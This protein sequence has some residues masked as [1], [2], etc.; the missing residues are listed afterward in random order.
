MLTKVTKFFARAGGT[1]ALCLLAPTAHAAPVLDALAGGWNDLD[2]FTT[3]GQC[4]AGPL[5]ASYRCSPALLSR[6]TQPRFEGK[7]L[8]SATDSV[9]SISDALR[10]ESINSGDIEKLFK[11]YNYSD[12]IA[13]VDLSYFGPSLTVGLRPIRYQ[14]QFQVHN[15]NLP[16]ASLAYRKDLD[17]HAGTGYGWQLGRLNLSAGALVSVVRREETLVEATLLDLAS[18][19]AKELI[20]KQKLTGYFFDFGANATWNE[21]LSA[22]VLA[23]D[24]GGWFGGKTDR[25]S[26]YLFLNPDRPRRIFTSLAVMPRLFTGRLQIGASAVHFLQ[27]KNSLGDQWFGTVSYY[28]G[29]TR[30]LSGF[31]PGL[32]RTG[33]ATRFS[34]FE[35]NVAQEW[36]N[37]LET[38][39]KA[40]P[41]FTLEITSGL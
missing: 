4:S 32:F 17:I 5:G 16:L 19:P 12:L 41:R 20:D 37:K 28:I 25:T 23:K 29:P 2:S 10:K 1:V 34:R 6:A 39:R 40:Q 22:S 9:L 35:V 18:R 31:R 13:E 24:F 7:G 15:P 27:Q 38:G 26:R 11:D 8:I 21:F 3:L 36:I 14:G 30:L 33:L